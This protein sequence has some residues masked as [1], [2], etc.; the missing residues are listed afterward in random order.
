MSLVCQITGK[1]PM[2]SKNVSHAKNRTTDALNQMFTRNDFGMNQ[3]PQIKAVRAGLNLRYLPKA[4]A[5][6]K[7]RGLRLFSVSY[8]R[9]TKRFKLKHI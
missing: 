1:R 2:S 5:L 4:C 3:N 6:S 8:K 7:K 9:G